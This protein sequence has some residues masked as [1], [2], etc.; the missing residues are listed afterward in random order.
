MGFDSRKR[1]SLVQAREL[2]VG[3]K[4]VD[5]CTK[6]MMTVFRVEPCRDGS[7]RVTH[8]LGDL[9]M[10]PSVQVRVCGAV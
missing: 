8:S 4:L 10:T 1:E 6:V 9:R 5:T 7:L 3:D 2:K